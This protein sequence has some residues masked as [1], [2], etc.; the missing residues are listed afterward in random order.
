MNAIRHWFAS[1]REPGDV[2][3]AAIAGIVFGLMMV[4]IVIAACL[5]IN[6][7]AGLR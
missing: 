3:R 7:I 6:F 2:R 1:L 5:V 4:V